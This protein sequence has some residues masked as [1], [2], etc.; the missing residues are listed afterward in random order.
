MNT[1]SRIVPG[2]GFWKNCVSA[3][4]SSVAG[5][6]RGFPVCPKIF[7]FLYRSWYEMPVSKILKK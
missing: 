5:G 3:V 7:S 1:P 4:L 2:Y 6:L